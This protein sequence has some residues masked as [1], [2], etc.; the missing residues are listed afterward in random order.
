MNNKDMAEDK[1]KDIVINDQQEKLLFQDVCS[2][3]EHGRQQAYGS[4]NHIAIAT[5][6]NVG[7]RIVEEEQNGEKH[8]VAIFRASLSC[9]TS[10]QCRRPFYRL[11]HKDDL[12]CL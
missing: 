9:S 11:Q 3:I 10:C 7:K 4:V 12:T 1:N 2:I 6:W 5:Y 8:L